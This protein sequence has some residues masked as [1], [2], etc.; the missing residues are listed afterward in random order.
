M[1]TPT[2]TR[3]E[4]IDFLKS[5]REATRELANT[6][7]SDKTDYFKKHVKAYDIAIEAINNEIMQEKMH[8]E[9]AK[10]LLENAYGKGELI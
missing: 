5:E 6:C 1:E 8:K 10:A 3:E 4:A 7:N 9:I 2:M